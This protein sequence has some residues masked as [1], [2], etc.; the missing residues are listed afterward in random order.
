MEYSRGF[1]PH[2]KMGFAQPLSLGYTSEG[3]Y[4]E[5]ET[6]IPYNTDH[7]TGLM[8][9]FLPYGIVIRNCIPVPSG[10]KSA[11]SLVRYAS[12]EAFFDSG[13]IPSEN[14]V[15]NFLAQ[16]EIIVKKPVNKRKDSVEINIKPM[17]RTLKIG[18]IKGDQQT[19]YMEINTGSIS[20]LNPELL[21]VSL[22][23]FSDIPYEKGIL[24]IKRIEMFKENGHPLI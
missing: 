5:F 13:M 19:I 17:I 21:L 2:P 6:V 22:F 9:S 8:N 10:E 23:E 4:L 3:E 12:Y 1:N 14:Q 7:I 15:T 11:A 20:N 18:E 24:Q 16:E